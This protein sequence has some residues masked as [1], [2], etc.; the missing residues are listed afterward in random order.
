[1]G[2]MVAL[3]RTKGFVLKHARYV[4]LPDHDRNIYLKLA[5]TAEKRDVIDLVRLSCNVPLILNVCSPLC[6]PY[7]GLHHL[8]N[9]MHTLSAPYPNRIAH[10]IY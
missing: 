10:H 3:K 5:K 7:G 6:G 4:T 1:M 9:S 2:H 8:T